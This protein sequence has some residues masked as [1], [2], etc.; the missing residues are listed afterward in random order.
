VSDQTTTITTATGQRAL[1]AARNLRSSSA[2]CPGSAGH[3]A[4]INGALIAQ[5]LNL[6]G[7]FW[8]WFENIDI[9]LLGFLVV[10]MFVAAWAIALSVWH[11]GHIEERWSPHLDEGHIGPAG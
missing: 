11:L 8:K 3:R 7:S 2:C 10:G 1:V 5:H 4:G 9:N 6:S